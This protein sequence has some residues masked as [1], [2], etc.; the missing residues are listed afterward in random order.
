MGLS[1][2]AQA[3]IMVLADDAD[4]GARPGTSTRSEE[5]LELVLWGGGK[6]GSIRRE[7]ALEVVLGVG[8]K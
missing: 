3:M 8:G 6:E 2:P 1:Q 4:P 5:T 7:E